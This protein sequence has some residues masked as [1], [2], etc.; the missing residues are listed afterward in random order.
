LMSPEFQAKAVERKA[1]AGE[2]WDG[3]KTGEVMAGVET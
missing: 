3:K 2:R 1:K